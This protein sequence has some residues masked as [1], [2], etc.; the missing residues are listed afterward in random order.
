MDHRVS[1]PRSTSRMLFPS[2]FYPG[3]KPA[4]CPDRPSRNVVNGTC[5]HSLAA[6][7]SRFLLHHAHLPVEIPKYSCSHVTSPSPC[8]IVGT[9]CTPGR[10]NRIA[11]GTLA[12]RTNL[13]IHHYPGPKRAIQDIVSA[14]KK[15]AIVSHSCRNKPGCGQPQST[16]RAARFSTTTFLLW[17]IPQAFRTSSAQRGSLSLRLLVSAGSPG[18]PNPS[19]IA[20]ETIL[21]IRSRL[22]AAHANVR[23][24]MTVRY[25]CELI[26]LHPRAISLQVRTAGLH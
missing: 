17:L 12:T 8:R 24:L 6:H 3:A 10:A 18:L 7:L 15:A 11:E 26:I 1:V 22:P 20:S 14:W 9:A 21:L 19:P 16:H 2:L 25:M 13:E 4:L 23:E 5:N